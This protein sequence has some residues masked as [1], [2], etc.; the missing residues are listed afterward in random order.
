MN[1]FFI[2]VP[3][4]PA[5]GHKSG[6][7]RMADESTEFEVTGIRAAKARANQKSVW[8]EAEKPRLAA[9]RKAEQQAALEA[10]GTGDGE[11]DEE[12]NVRMNK[13]NRVSGS[14]R[15]T[16]TGRKSKKN[17]SRKST[18]RQTKG[19]GISRVERMTQSQPA[20]DIFAKQYAE[21]AEEDEEELILPQSQPALGMAAVSDEINGAA[22]HV[23]RKGS[24]RPRTKPN[25]G[26]ASIMHRAGS[27]GEGASQHPVEE[28]DDND[29]DQ[30]E[31]HGS[32]DEEEEDGKDDE[33][34]GEEDG[35]DEGNTDLEKMDDE[36]L[37]TTLRR[38]RPKVI[39]RPSA[40]ESDE[41]KASPPPSQLP[42]MRLLNLKDVEAQVRKSK[43]VS[44][45]S[46]GRHGTAPTQASQ[47]RAPHR[48][49][50]GT[51]QNAE[52]TASQRPQG[53]RDKA[54][55]SERPQ[56]KPSRRRQY[57]PSA[58]PTPAPV[59][60]SW[61]PET[62]LVLSSIGRIVIK[63]QNPTMTI[64]CEHVKF[65]FTSALYAYKAYP[66]AAERFRT[67]HHLLVIAVEDIID[68]NQDEPLFREVLERV[69]ADSNY[70]KFLIDMGVQHM[71]SLRTEL[72]KTVAMF[73]RDEYKVSPMDPERI[74]KWMHK[75]AYLY[76]GDIEET[77]DTK[78][79]LDRPIFHTILKKCFFNGPHSV[80]VR[81]PQIWQGEYHKKTV[82][83]ALMVLIGTTI[84]VCLS[85]LLLPGAETK[86]DAHLKAGFFEAEYLRVWKELNR[87]FEKSP[88]KF[89]HKMHKLYTQA[90]QGVVIPSVEEDSLMDISGMSESESEN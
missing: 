73:V 78:H 34:S 81:H 90:S 21:L 70:S 58:S 65:T 72:K 16:A 25:G 14:S 55:I 4:S 5:T 74:R 62:N 42:P 51:N 38:E 80:A 43:Q 64:V 33:W 56:V 84:G 19:K 49:P 46:E 41:E 66:P 85:E 40:D 29:N 44:R 68:K 7:N 61:S 88:N 27:T 6:R 22:P 17:T 13:R 57:A 48:S 54:M 37:G 86:P 60:R 23:S 69:H 9:K 1:S 67:H 35:D 36:E 20:E 39:R 47:T 18:G 8:L 31:Y 2:D 75:V 52:L 77:L 89:Y 15:S 11:A 79:V 3:A 50:N 12:V 45:P 76:P 53:C 87:L 71:S 82:P 32:D 10:G 24:S 26:N 83:G 63:G 59:Q 30:E 28:D